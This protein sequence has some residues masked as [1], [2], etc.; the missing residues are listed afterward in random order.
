[1]KLCI[2]EN[3]KGVIRLYIKFDEVLVSKDCVWDL[4]EYRVIHVDVYE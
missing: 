1:M 2:L 3:K 4:F